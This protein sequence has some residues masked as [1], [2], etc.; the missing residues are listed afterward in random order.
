MTE[1]PTSSIPLSGRS[2]ETSGGMPP[3]LRRLLS[4]RLL[5]MLV[6][7]LLLTIYFHVR[8][9]RHLLLAAQRHPAAAQAS[10][11]AVVAAGVSILMVMGEIDLSIGSAA[12]LC[13]VVLGHSAGVVLDAHAAGGS[14][15]HRGRGPA[16]RLA[17][18]CG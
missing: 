11:V 12:Y 14:H 7:F 15:H 4:G 5:S 8:L 10:I 1:T 17:C 6:V 18:G 9:Q 16:R 13:S 3:L 2:Q